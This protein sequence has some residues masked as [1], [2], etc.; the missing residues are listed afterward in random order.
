MTGSEKSSETAC[1]GGGDDG[2]SQFAKK[3]VDGGG[4]GGGKSQSNMLRESV[5]A[6]AAFII[7][8]RRG[9]RAKNS[10]NIYR[11]KYERRLRHAPLANDAALLLP[12]KVYVFEGLTE[13]LPKTHLWRLGTFLPS[14]V[15]D[16]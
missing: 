14:R 16:P 4:G 8:A 10:S 5:A 2:T 3:F 7:V 11:Y 13:S 1:G 12:R 6:S 15:T 9:R